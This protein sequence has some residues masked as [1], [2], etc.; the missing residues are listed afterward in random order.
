MSQHDPLNFMTSFGAKL[1]TRSRHVCVFLGAGAS[2]ACGLPDVTG[3]QKRV[4]EKLNEADR[5][6]LA[7]QLSG[8]NLEQALSRLRRIAALLN[9][10]QTID[11][12]T[13]AE[14]GSLDK[15][16]CKTIVDELDLA[17]ADL[18]PAVA[19]AAWIARS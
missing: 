13:A 5:K 11:G 4:L 1:A 15:S 3:L 9:D 7:T 6:A 17:K 12:L 16:I 19:F 8:R 2:R 14:A 18:A 10:N